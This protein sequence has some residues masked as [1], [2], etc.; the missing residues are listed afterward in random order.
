VRGVDEEHVAV[1]E[2]LDLGRIEIL[3]ANPTNLG[4]GDVP[5]RVRE[6]IR[7]EDLVFEGAAG[8]PSASL[9]RLAQSMT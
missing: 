5:H 9:A 2:P 4:C 3:A 7:I 6:R 1:G 8:L